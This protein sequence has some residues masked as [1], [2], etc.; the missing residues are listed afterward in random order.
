M[1]VVTGVLIG[2]LRLPRLL[3]G[4]GA[5]L[6][7]QPVALALEPPGVVPPPL[8]RSAARPR[9]ALPGAAIDRVGELSLSG[10][11][12]LADPGVRALPRRG[13]PGPGGERPGLAVETVAMGILRL[14]ALGELLG[15][16]LQLTAVLP[17]PT[18]HPELLVGQLVALRALPVTAGGGV[19]LTGLLLKTCDLP[20]DVDRIGR[21]H[22][23]DPVALHAQ[24]GDRIPRPRSL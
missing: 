16:F 13:A 11:E 20:L 8:P 2:V 3:V 18:Q 6:L 5:Q 24:R 15:V 17:A 21:Q 23:G 1:R 22:R 7:T 4:V 9:L 10:M 19:G 12:L 14:S